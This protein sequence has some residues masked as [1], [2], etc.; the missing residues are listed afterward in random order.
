MRILKVGVSVGV[1]LAML[2]A[3]VLTAPQQ[4]DARPQYLK[5]FATQYPSVAEEAKKVK[6]G[7]CHPEK[8]KKVRSDYGKAMGSGLTKKNE[9]D[10]DAL[11]TALTKAESAESGVEGKTFGDLIKAGMLPK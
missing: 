5:A 4:A 3:M 10:G 7:V 1:G 6:C 11:K 9:K 8:S 2:A